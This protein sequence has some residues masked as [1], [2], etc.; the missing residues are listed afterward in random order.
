[1]FNVQRQN[2]ERL[3]SGIQIIQSK[4]KIQQRK[5]LKGGTRVNNMQI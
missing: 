2:L 1:M 3:N 5:G 4:M